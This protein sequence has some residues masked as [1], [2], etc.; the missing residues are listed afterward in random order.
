MVKHRYTDFKVLSMCVT[1]E[2]SENERPGKTFSAGTQPML[3]WTLITRINI[4]CNEL[5]PNFL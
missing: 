1:F 2:N 5:V 3:A 4:I